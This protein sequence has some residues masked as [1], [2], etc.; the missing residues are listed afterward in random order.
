VRGTETRSVG[1]P[2][3][4]VPPPGAPA[5]RR[6]CGK[7]AETAALPGEEWRSRGYLPHREA[8]GLIQM[9]TFR[10]ADSLPVEVLDELRRDRSLRN[11]AKRR[12]R[13]EAYLDAAHGACHLRDPAAARMVEESLL[14]FDGGRYHLLAWSIM[15][16]HVHVLIELLPGHTLAKTLHSWKSYTAHAANRALGRAGTF[17]QREYWD[18]YVRDE[19]HLA[20][21]IRYIHGNRSLYS[22]AQRAM[23]TADERVVPFEGRTEGGRRDGG[24]PSQL[25]T[26]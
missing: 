1:R 8:L 20:S 16:N 26:D 11:D 6:H 15:P 23:G 4:E 2:K 21:A 10:L 14:R 18:R 25:R 17:W 3:R 22:S 13:V 19:E 9:V 24:A 12:E 7:V 5:S